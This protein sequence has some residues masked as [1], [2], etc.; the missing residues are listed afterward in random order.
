VPA[1][2]PRTQR[3]RDTVGDSADNGVRR[4]GLKRD[5]GRLEESRVHPRFGVHPGITCSKNDV[6]DAI[7]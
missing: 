1:S 5:G 7:Q 4:V 6:K 3:K 2:V